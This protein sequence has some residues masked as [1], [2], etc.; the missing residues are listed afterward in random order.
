MRGAAGFIAVLLA[1]SL[2]A[3]GKTP[4][5]PALP[6][7]VSVSPLAVSDLPG[8]SSDSQTLALPALRASCAVVAK[9]DDTA[10]VGAGAMAVSAQAW[11]AACIG[12]KNIDQDGDVAA[13]QKF[14][15]SRFNA[16]AVTTNGDGQQG[17]FTGYYQ[18]VLAGCR[19]RTATCQTPLYGVPTDLVSL[20]AATIS[21]D[22]P[23]SVLAGRLEGGRLV[24]YW[25][26]AEIEAGALSP[27]GSSA[28]PVVAW[29]ESPIEAH[30]LSIQGSGVVRMADGSLLMVGYAG[31]NGRPYKGLG[32][33]LIDQ[34]VLT[35]PQVGMPV[36]RDWLV[37]HPA[38]APAVMRQNPR[39]IF[40]K[41]TG[42]FPAGESLA[43]SNPPPPVGS[44]GVPLVAGRTLAVDA[45]II[46]LGAWVWLD[47]TDPDGQPLRRL[48]VA[49]DTGSAI[50][51]VVRGDVFWG[52]G[53]AA[54]DGA[55]RM[56]SPGRWFV[57]VPK[58]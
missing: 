23:A 32:K 57:L 15:N 8:W 44:L 54:F 26:R 46:P 17:L 48:M 19:D 37:S 2:V 36:I 12:L 9:H 13:L 56:K 25:S 16:F 52:S 58:G 35:L 42:E 22:F 49:A 50:R 39:M 33:I 14:L 20:E 1:L 11:K 27:T 40:F 55:G 34:G 10:W 28:A 24:P 3:C 18:P 6:P 41:R 5:P 30:I 45:S 7:G 47:S 4:A 31:N 43:A 21:A 53:E 29:V 38:Q 51:G